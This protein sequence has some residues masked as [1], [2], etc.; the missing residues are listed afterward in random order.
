MGRDHGLRLGQ[1]A[2][3]SYADPPRIRLSAYSIAEDAE[4]GDAVGTLSVTNGAGVYTF[5]ITADAD[6]KFAI[7]GDAL[8]LDATVDF[9]TAVSHGVTV[10]ADNGDDDPILRAFTVGVTDV[11]E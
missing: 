8:E 2:G 10:E 1:R 3:K 6:S 11:A 5:S 7:D 4:A 9:E